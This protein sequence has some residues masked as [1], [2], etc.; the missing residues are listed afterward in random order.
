MTLLRAKNALRAYNT[1]T[2]VLFGLKPILYNQR[3]LGLNYEND[4]HDGFHPPYEPPSL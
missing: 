4:E 3:K 2:S 1:L